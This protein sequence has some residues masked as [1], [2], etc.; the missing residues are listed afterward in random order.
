MTRRNLRTSLGRR[1]SGDPMTRFDGLPPELRRW[2]AT[3]ALPWSASSALRLWRRAMAE[4][5]CPD[6]ARTC[7]CAAEERSL[8]R[9]APHVWGTTHPAAIPN[10]PTSNGNQQ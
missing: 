1:A 4:C 10:T 5:A 6:H 3:A 8:A 9:D 7:L 2:L